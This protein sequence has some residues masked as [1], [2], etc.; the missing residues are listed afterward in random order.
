MK[1]AIPIEERFSEK[2]I[3]QIISSFS[4]EDATIRESSI[5]F[6]KLSINQDEVKFDPLDRSLPLILW[7]LAYID[8]NSFTSRALNTYRDI[9]ESRLSMETIE[10]VEYYSFEYGVNATYNPDLSCYV[11]DPEI[12]ATYSR[13]VSGSKFRLVN[14]TFLNGKILMD[15]D[16]LHKVIREAFLVKARNILE[17]IDSERCHVILSSISEELLDLQE[18]AR[19]MKYSGELGSVDVSCFPPCILHYLADA[20]SGVNLPHMARF[21]MVS[22]LHHVGMKNEEIM[23]IFKSAPDFNERITS[24]QVNHVTGEK[25]G[26]E[27]SPP[28]CSVL[29]SN[30][31]CYM[32]NDYIC[33]S[34]WLKHPMQYYSYKKRKKNSGKPSLNNL[35]K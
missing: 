24:Y 4:E 2:S 1:R 30:H 26:T 21:T 29:K 8:I 6:L 20:R 9:F 13:R 15:G 18:K 17:S 25:S 12:F 28:R 31:L 33:N 35:D 5:K 19:E 23:N 11:M 7:E 22:F 3:K 10:K 16:V 27:Y 32:D 14:Q 34:E